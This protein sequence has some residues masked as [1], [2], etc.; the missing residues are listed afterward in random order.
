MAAPGETSL[1]LRCELRWGCWHTEL[2]AAFATL[3]MRPPVVG[4]H[5][6]RP[7]VTAAVW[8]CLS[9]LTTTTSRRQ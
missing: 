9:V 1:T 4:F 5:R 3:P 7:V 8:R 2:P 6:Q